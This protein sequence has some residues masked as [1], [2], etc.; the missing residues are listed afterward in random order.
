LGRNLPESI[1]NALLLKV[2]EGD[3]TAFRKLH[4][5]YG[6]FIRAVIRKYISD[7][8]ECREITQQVFIALWERREALSDLKSFD[9][10]LFI[11]T[12]NKVFKYFSNLRKEALIIKELENH[13]VPDPQSSGLNTELRE[14]HVLWE[15]AMQMLP[16]QQKQVYT[17]IER[18][19]ET[20]DHVAKELGLARGTVKKHLELAR[21]AVRRFIS[22]ELE[23]GRSAKTMIPLAIV[24]LFIF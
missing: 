21:K 24:S 4:D 14:Y 13:D 6:S 8:D 20:V 1:G 5:A 10:Y 11:V 17:M 12:R 7:E 23:G 18:H 9:D 15:R 19:E 22:G 2:S 16:A 3:S